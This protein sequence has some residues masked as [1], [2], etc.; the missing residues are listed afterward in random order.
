MATRV[1]SNTTKLPS[2]LDFLEKTSLAKGLEPS[3]CNADGGPVGSDCSPRDEAR[4][5]HMDARKKIKQK[6]RTKF[7]VQFLSPGW[8]RLLTVT[9]YHPGTTISMYLSTL[10]S[11]FRV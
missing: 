9:N 10:P 4:S 6:H 1:D 5:P 2:E 3:G 11:S 7:R 8:R